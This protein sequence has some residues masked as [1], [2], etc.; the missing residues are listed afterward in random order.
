[1]GLGMIAIII[2]RIKSLLGYDLRAPMRK[3]ASER[4]L[5]AMCYVGKC[6]GI[7]ASNEIALI[8]K[9]ASRLTR[10]N[11]VA[12]DVIRITDQIDMNL[13]AQDFI[14]FGRGLRDREKDVM[15]LGA[16]YVALSSGRILKSEH[17]FLTQLSH[18]IGMP[19]E[20]FRRVM[21]IALE[22]L[23]RYPPNL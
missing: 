7:V 9:A 1:L 18:G 12:A 16:F 6:D 4:I 22:D 5:T 20:D 8:R 13:S 2:R 15:M 14:D 17:E 19:A 23:D 10:R 11:Y 3:K 21:N